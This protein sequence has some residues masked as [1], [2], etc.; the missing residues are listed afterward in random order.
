[1]TYQ[2]FKD[3]NGINISDFLEIIDELKNYPEEEKIAVFDFDNTLIHGDIGEA[4]FAQMIK[5]KKELNYSWTEYTDALN[6]GNTQEAYKRLISSYDNLHR[7]LIISY[8]EEVFQYDDKNPKYL[9]FAEKGKF[10]SV[11]KPM[12]NRLLNDIILK[13]QSLQFKIYI[14][15]ASSDISVKYLGKKLFDIPEEQIFGMKNTFKD[16]AK[17]I[18]GFEIELPAPCFEGKAELYK[19]EIS[20]YPPLF[21]AGDSENDIAFMNLTSDKGFKLIVNKIEDDINKFQTKVHSFQRAFENNR[22][23]FIVKSKI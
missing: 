10:Y 4:I 8:T 2:I 23:I 5:N 18:L 19:K 1:M 14:I 20:N 6:A 21:T 16:S 11:P 15:S 9:G 3:E 7:D 17:E 12:P 13:L 22:N